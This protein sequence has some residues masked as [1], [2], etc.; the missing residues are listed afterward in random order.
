[1]ISL[2][3]VPSTPERSRMLHRDRDHEQHLQLMVSPTNRQHVRQNSEYQ[4]SMV[5]PDFRHQVIEAQNTVQNTSVQAYQYDD[6]FQSTWLGY[7]NRN[8][9]VSLFICWMLIGYFLTHYQAYDAGPSF[10][11]QPSAIS[12]NQVDYTAQL[13]QRFNEAHSNRRQHCQREHCMVNNGVNDI[14]DTNGLY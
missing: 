12:R 2:R 14:E 4:E 7:D 10:V 6:V 13:I 5:Q 3:S 9:S 8:V 11:M 1:M